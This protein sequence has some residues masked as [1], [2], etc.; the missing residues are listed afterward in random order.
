[1]NE[2]VPSF[3]EIK[4]NW[5]KYDAVLAT[6]YTKH[7]AGLLRSPPYGALEDKLEFYDMI[8]RILSNL[9]QKMFVPYR[10]IDVGLECE[11]SLYLI[12]KII[13]PTSKVVIC[14]SEIPSPVNP[15]I[16]SRFVNFMVEAAH[17]TNVPVIHLQKIPQEITE[18]PA[19]DLRKDSLVKHTLPRDAYFGVEL[20]AT[21]VY[22]IH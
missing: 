6:F 15:Y 22:G 17:K 14:D 2:K 12:E 4:E 19:R 8:E 18:P 20:L 10:D 11:K 16:T 5:G 9:G 13:I 3:K 7:S 21:Q 1:M